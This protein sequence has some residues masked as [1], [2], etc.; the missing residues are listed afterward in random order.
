[1]TDR[2]K[3]CVVT[4]DRDYRDDD[5]EEILGAI[6]MIKGVISVEGSLRN[7]DDS[8]NREVI[9]QRYE[10]AIRNAIDTA[11]VFGEVGVR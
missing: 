8:I 10:R 5:V 6:K 9:K 7:I 11:N 3:G 1:M 2:V 4:F